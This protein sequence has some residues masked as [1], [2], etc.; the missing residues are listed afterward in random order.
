[1]FDKRSDIIRF[2]A[3]V[4]A[5]AIN[6]AADRLAMT[7]PALTRV[8][9]RL[10]HQFAGKLFERLP[11][12]MRLTELG[13]AADTLA[14]R[15]LCELTAAEEQFGAVLAGRTGIFRITAGPVWIWTILPKVIAEFHRAFPGIEI[16]VDPA[17]RAEGLLRLANGTIDLHCGGID[18]G[19]RVPNF[20]RRER[21]FDV[22]A[23][24][25]AHPNHP[26]HTRSITL[27]DLARYP[28]IDYDPYMPLVGSSSQTSLSHLL[29]KVHERS[30]ARVRTIVRT[31]SASLLLLASAPYLS[32]LS[33][34]LIDRMREGL[35]R[36][37]P[38]EFG[39]FQY[40]TGFAVLR[41]SEDL[42]AFRRF[43][44]ILRHTMLNWRG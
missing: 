40:R 41:S 20:V 6:L 31:S 34:T 43:V 10:E 13:K 12:G 23:G 30:S 8:I 38:M 44:A 14:R 3:V 4:E 33:L 2:L 22:T 37:L 18:N 16:R 27:E 28:W 36:P 1:M 7:Q 24:I 5:G 21:F 39:R 26:L 9:S 17:T 19:E 35:V 15:V 11:K 25:V 32:W 29:E 42:P